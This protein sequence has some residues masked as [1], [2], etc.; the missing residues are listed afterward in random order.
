MFLLGCNFGIGHHFKLIQVPFFG[1]CKMNPSNIWRNVTLDIYKI[2][3]LR[4]FV[5]M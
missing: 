1:M 2:F 5:K 3:S 4:G